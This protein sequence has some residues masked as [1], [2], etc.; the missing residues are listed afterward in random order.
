MTRFF[1]LFFSLL[2][3]AIPSA[4]S[5]QVFEKGYILDDQK[6]RMVGYIQMEKWTSTGTISYRLELRGETRTRPMAEVLEFGVDGSFR[7]IHQPVFTSAFGDTEGKL[8]TWQ[9]ARLFLW[10]LVDG[11]SSLFVYENEKKSVYFFQV[12]QSPIEQLMI[13]DEKPPASGS[14]AQQLLFEKVNCS[15]STRQHF[16][17]VIR[18]RAALVKHFLDDNACKRVTGTY[19]PR[20]GQSTA[21]SAPP[22]DVPAPPNSAR[23]K[24]TYNYA[25][26]ELNPLLNQILDFDSDD[27]ETGNQFT[28]QY[29]NNNRNS[30]KG[31]SAAFS[32][33]RLSTK[34]TSTQIDRETT[35][36]ALALRV[37]YER[38]HSIGKR[39]ILLHGYDFLLGLTKE[40]TK[41]NHL[42]FQV[43]IESTGTQWGLGPRAGI[44]FGISD[45]VFLG[46]EST[47]Y[48]T[49]LKEK[50]TITGQPDS[51][52]KSSEFLIVL[53]VSLFLTVRLNN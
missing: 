26:V 43:D 42:G 49:F 9:E 22:V 38:K 20:G 47:F 29:A 31:V 6:N 18:S 40:Y 36:R 35:E 4:H 39:W 53:P 51:E 12:N 23:L 30:G 11:P 10:T 32:Y 8:P 50:Q 2:W 25:G 46:T 19:Y 27:Q 34:E 15:D 44:M 37:G 7:I 28:V 5:Q 1:W 21:P 16:A 14:T 45:Q 24:P 52:Q 13:I 17:R 33:R 3:A 48:L 41:S